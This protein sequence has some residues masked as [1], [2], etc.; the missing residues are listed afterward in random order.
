MFMTDVEDEMC[1]WQVVINIAVTDS[2]LLPLFCAF[3]SFKMMFTKS[4]LNLGSPTHSARKNPVFIYKGTTTRMITLI[5][6]NHIIGAWVMFWK[7]CNNL[8]H[9]SCHR[10]PVLTVTLRDLSFLLLSNSTKHSYKVQLHILQQWH[11]PVTKNSKIKLISK[12]FFLFIKWWKIR[13]QDIFRF[14]TLK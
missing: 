14:N 3:V 1:W 9:R 5:Y 2:K 4:Y 12:S 13:R 8:W 11:K 10:T 7:R 6:W